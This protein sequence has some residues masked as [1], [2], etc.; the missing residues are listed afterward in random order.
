M[1]RLNFV[2]SKKILTSIVNHNHE[3]APHWRPRYFS[4]KSNLPQDSL[5]KQ[6]RNCG[7]F[8]ATS[9]FCDRVDTKISK[10]NSSYYDAAI[11]SSLLGI[12]QNLES[13]DDS[14]LT[15][16]QKH[17]LVPLNFISI[18]SDATCANKF[19]DS[20]CR[21]SGLTIINFD[22]IPITVIPRSINILT[23]L[24]EFTLE[25]CPITVLPPEIGE[26]TNLTY[27]QLNDT[28]VSSF[29]EEFRNLTNLGIIRCERNHIT[30]FTQICS[31]PKLIE[32]TL[33]NNMI[34][35]IHSEIRGLTYLLELNLE[36]NQIKTIPPEIQTL[37]SLTSFKMDRNMIT[38]LPQEI[39]YLTN[40]KTLTFDYNNIRAIIPSIAARFGAI[41]G[42]MKISIKNNPISTS[43][44][45][46][47]TKDLTKNG[48]KVKWI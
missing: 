22:N 4:R 11:L 20:V 6:L 14:G 26:L 45:K 5:P 8:E 35:E 36:G 38:T 2:L 46:K 21:I 41:K 32:I 40:I 9:F 29:P 10:F 16:D 47:I 43:P 15:F 31:L 44:P 3:E 13:L 30:N 19:F 34:T 27:F 7:G 1:E 28:L 17:A 25:R 24:R 37:T 33:A 39:T 48:C 23:N 42:L 18:Q 12:D